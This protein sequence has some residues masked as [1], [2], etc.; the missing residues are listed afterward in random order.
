MAEVRRHMKHYGRSG[1]M[2]AYNECVETM[3]MLKR[4][5]HDTVTQ[6]KALLT[7]EAFSALILRSQIAG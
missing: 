4:Q 2:A 7:P 6:A 1:N 5:A 3:R